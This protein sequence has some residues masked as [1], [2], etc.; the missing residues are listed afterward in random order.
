MANKQELL[1]FL[2]QHVFNPILQAS[3]DRYS[4][5]DRQKLKDV[6]DRTRSEKERFRGYSSAQRLLITTTAIHTLLRQSG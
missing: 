4:E 1:H 5:S 3:A 2:D 6:R